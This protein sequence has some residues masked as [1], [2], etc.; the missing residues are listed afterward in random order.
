MADNH[1]LKVGKGIA[2]Q[3]KVSGFTQAHVA[4]RLGI[5]KETVSRIET[6]VIS[7]TLTRLYQFTELFNCNIGDFFWLEDND[8]ERQTMIIMD[9]L[10][11]LPDEKRNF[12]VGFIKQLT[13]VMK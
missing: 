10:R 8:A 3:R 1:L 11:E 9:L 5:K 12:V 13:Q 4:E 2:K 7:P 6:G